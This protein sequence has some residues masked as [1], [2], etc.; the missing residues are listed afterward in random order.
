MKFNA[1]NLKKAIKARL[2]NK[3]FSLSL[4]AFVVGLSIFAYGVVKAGSPTDCDGN[5]VI[6]CGVYDQNVMVSQYNANTNGV[7]DIYNHFQIDG[8]FSGLVN[9]VVTRDNRVLVNGEEVATDALTTGRQSIGNSEAISLGGRTFY[10]RQPS[11]SFSSSSIPAYV[12]IVNGQFKWAV[13]KSCGNPVQGTPKPTPTP[14]Y[15]IEKRVIVN[16]S[17]DNTDTAYFFGQ[18]SVTVDQGTEVRFV[19]MIYNANNVS[20]GILAFDDLPFGADY[21]SGTFQVKNSAGVISQT[22][23]LVKIEGNRYGTMLPLEAGGEIKLDIL[24]KYTA[25]KEIENIAC[26]ENGTIGL[27]ACDNATV[28][29]KPTPPPVPTPSYTCDT[30]TIEEVTKGSFKLLVKG[31]VS[32]G[33]NITG[34]IFKVNDSEVYNGSAD[35]YIYNQTTPGSYTVKAF[36]KTD[37]GTT[38]EVAGCTKI[39]TISAP[40]EKPSYTIKKYVNGKDAQDNGSSVEVKP[41][42]E[43]EYKV[44]VKNT[45][46]VAINSIK[47]WDVLPSGVTYVGGSLKLD[48]QAVANDTNFFDPAKGVE[49]KNLA[50]SREAVFTFKAKINASSP[51]EMAKAC[52]ANGTFYNNIAKADPAK[53]GDTDLPE[54]QDPAVIKCKHT[55]NPKYTIKKY[56]EE[57][58]AQTNN[59]AL[60]VSPNQAFTYKVVIENT[61]DVKLNNVKAWDVLPSGVTY[62]SGSLKLDGQAVAND[63]DYFNAQKGVIVQNINVGQKVEFTFQAKIAATSEQEMAKACDANG[64]FYNNIAKA[65][66][67]SANGNSTSSELNEKQDPAVIKCTHTPKVDHPSVVI[68]KEVSQYEVNVGQQFT[69]YVSVTN[70]GDIDLKNVV[71]ND[72]APEGTEFISSATIEGVNIDVNAKAF[73]AT[74]ANLKVGQKVTFSIQAKLTT[75]K[76]ADIVN[77]ACVNAPEVNPSQPTKEDDC[78]D[79]KIKPVEKCSVPGKENLDKNDP[80]CKEMC[81][82]KGKENLAKNDPNC[83]DQNC[84]EVNGKMVSTVGKDGCENPESPTKINNTPATTPNTGLEI[85]ASVLTVGASAAA[86]SI[87]KVISKRKRN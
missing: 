6:R 69:W 43:F 18:Q 40:S 27:K 62:V 21:I 9:G 20:G 14:T 59:D 66:P 53:Q 82:I 29:P 38:T 68:E 41:G 72:E 26:V 74:I 58:D 34:Y 44:V 83:K 80:N 16:N 11:V 85:A 84:I 3:A 17:G 49:I 65:D 36:V 15:G 7:K 10:K 76:N 50:A 61:G 12:K 57:R 35:N 79:A 1:T 75:Y 13:L 52:D 39:I 77:T 42:E 37:K 47:A 46:K 28:K 22:G 87:T 8:D 32:G 86:F 5:A 55:T 4:I 24:A 54:S 60:T 81:T 64:T 70:N 71:V 45:S 48:G 56:V 73:K 31:S 63:Q 78:D 51:E 33:A 19:S 25:D 30:L 67:E 2:S 23:N